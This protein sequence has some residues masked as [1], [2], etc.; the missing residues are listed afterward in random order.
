MRLGQSSPKMR[1]PGGFIL[2]GGFAPK[3]PLALIFLLPLLS[4]MCFP[5]LG[6]FLLE[7]VSQFS[8]KP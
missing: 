4:L 1:A 8:P 2:C 3:P 7:I 5:K 6:G